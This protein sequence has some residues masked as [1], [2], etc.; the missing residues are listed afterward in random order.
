MGGTPNASTV[1][2]ACDTYVSKNKA[3]AEDILI[4]VTGDL[5]GLP[6]ALDLDYLATKLQ[7]CI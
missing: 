5:K 7:T 3:G 4:A 6:E 2:N 1:K